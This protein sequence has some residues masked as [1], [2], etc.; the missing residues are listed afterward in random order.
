M[1]NFVLASSNQHKAEEFKILFDPSILNV[2]SASQSIEVEETGETFLENALLKAKTYYDEF[3]KPVMADD[4][5]LV[6]Q[7]LPND[8]GVKTARFGGDGLSAK[9]RCD[10]L[11]DKMKNIKDEDRSAY[12][13]CYLCFY[14]NPKEVFFFEGRVKGKIAYQYRGEHGFGYDPVFIP[15]DLKEDKTL[16]EVP[17]WKDQ[18]SHRA[19]ACKEALKFFKTYL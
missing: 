4:S 17:L 3:K 19:I 13:V 16:A 18:N 14:L 1:H 10:L 12:F 7:A 9:Q 5:G 2:E 11:L 6:V 8:L 15:T